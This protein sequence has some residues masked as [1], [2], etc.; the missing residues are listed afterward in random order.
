MTHSIRSHFDH[1]LRS[2]QDNILRMGGLVDEAVQRSIR[3]LAERDLALA[4]QVVV[5]DFKV[6]DLRFKVENQCQAL[7]A[8]QQPTATDL[9]TIVAAM[10]IILDLERM[11]DH[12]AGIAKITLKVGDQP[13]LTP[14]VDISRMAD[15]AR[16]M[17]RT[18]LDAYVA[19][20][21]DAAKS[22][23]QRDDVVDE[24]YHQVFRDLVNMI[25]DD[26]AAINRGLH[27]LFAAHNLERIGDRSVNIAERAIYIASGEMKELN[28]K[29]EEPDPSG[30][31]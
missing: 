21:V 25:A 11:A 13:L 30:L 3:A 22:I 14:L 24:L 6:N 4:R 27:L 16:G 23:A 31:N 1:E 17:I 12:A 28:G 26:R 19:R 18:A 10:N 8:T 20:D 7:I 9:R 29:A 2:M 5:D 15:E